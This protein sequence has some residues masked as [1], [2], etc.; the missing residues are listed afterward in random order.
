M[1]Q[2]GIAPDADEAQLHATQIP[3]A[4][5]VKD[6]HEDQLV[7]QFVVEP[8]DD[9]VMLRESNECILTTRF[10][11]LASLVESAVIDIG[12]EAGANIEPGLIVKAGG[13]RSLV[14]QIPIN[15]DNA[16]YARFR[17][18]SDYGLT[19]RDMQHGPFSNRL[20]SEYVFQCR[21]D[22]RSISSKHRLQFLPRACHQ[23]SHRAHRYAKGFG[24][25]A[26]V[27]TIEV[28][29]RQR[30]AVSRRQAPDGVPDPLPHFDRL[31]LLQGRLAGRRLSGELQLGFDI[32]Q[33]IKVR[34]KYPQPIN[35]NAENNTAK[36]RRELG[37][38][39]Q[40]VEIQPRA[41]ERFLSQVLSFVS[42]VDQKARQPP[43]R[44]LVTPD[45]LAIGIAVSGPLPSR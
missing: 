33:S 19:I 5:P 18:R 3:A 1:I 29:E 35:R 37:R 27:E 39:T 45:Q 16:R 17:Q 14:H 32:R 24:D 36:P 9:L 15:R 44:A 30:Q 4:E 23:R 28:K 13:S 8:D 43:D 42:I 31:E 22:F 2:A 40:Q 34:P 26:V 12:K 20:L 10:Q 41:Q 6:F 7:R 11:I 38:I 25:L 21:K